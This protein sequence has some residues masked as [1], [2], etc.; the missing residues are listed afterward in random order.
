VHAVSHVQEVLR[1]WQRARDEGWARGLLSLISI[2][3][4]AVSYPKM[5]EAAALC[6]RVTGGGLDPQ[7]VVSILSTVAALM[8][9]RRFKFVEPQRRS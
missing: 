2:P 9:H 3:V 8:L 6:H 1:I 7:A 5:G 4:V